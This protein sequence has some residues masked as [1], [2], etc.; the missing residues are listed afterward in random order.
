MSAYVSDF[1]R[2][3]LRIQKG[4]IVAIVGLPDKADPTC[5]LRRLESQSL[6]FDLRLDR[7]DYVVDFI[8]VRIATKWCLSCEGR[9]HLVEACLSRM[10]GMRM[11][12][13]IKIT[14]QSA[15]NRIV[16]CFLYW[17]PAGLNSGTHF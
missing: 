6:A 8:V 3:M 7:G 2:K 5:G 10:D 15:F 13:Y 4:K 16:S 17:H 9:L 12:D 1:G 11:G 14:T